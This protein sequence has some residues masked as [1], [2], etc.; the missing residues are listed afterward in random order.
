MDTSP[1]PCANWSI[2]GNI[3]ALDLDAELLAQA[4]QNCKDN[5]NFHATLGDARELPK[6]IKQPVIFFVIANTFHGVPDK[7]Y[8]ALSTI[9]AINKIINQEIIIVIKV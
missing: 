3:W 6:Q 5:T 2:R 4:G 8:Q 9:R 7:T 1:N